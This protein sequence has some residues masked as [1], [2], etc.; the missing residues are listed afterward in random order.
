MK[1]KMKIEE[2][3]KLLDA[4]ARQLDQDTAN[5]LRDAR[6][7]ALQHQR[8][9]QDVFILALLRRFATGQAEGQHRTLNWAGVILL[10]AIVIGALWYWQQGYMH[11]HAEIDLAILTDDLPLHMYVD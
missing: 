2:I 9:L 3:G 10:A 1:R 11:S 6:T 7:V 8:S 5:R 4:A